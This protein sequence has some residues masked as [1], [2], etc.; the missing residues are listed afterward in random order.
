MRELAERFDDPSLTT[1]LSSDP[2]IVAEASLELFERLRK[3]LHVTVGM[4]PATH[5]SSLESLV[6]GEWNQDREFATLANCSP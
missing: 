6:V 1:L 2:S 5:Y 4:P 3:R